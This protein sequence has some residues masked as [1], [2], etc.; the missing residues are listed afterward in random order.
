[1]SNYLTGIESKCSEY[2]YEIKSHANKSTHIAN[3]PNKYKVRQYDMDE[4]FGDRVSK[5][6]YLVLN[7]DK[8]RA[9]FIELKTES[10]VEEAPEQIETS[11][12]LLKNE[13]P[14]YSHHL[15][16]VANLPNPPRIK[17]Y[18]IAEW[19]IDHKHAEFFP[20]GKC[21]ENV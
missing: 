6:D 3:N 8:K 13:I 9:Y 10:N 19:Q 4:V 5:C 11:R 21:V 18:I 16:I 17:M 2:A 15:R 7:D 20:N 14:K 1:M 12:N